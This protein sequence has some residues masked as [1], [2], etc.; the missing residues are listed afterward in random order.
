VPDEVV[1]I[2]RGDLLAGRDA[3]LEAA[4]AWIDTRQ[5]VRQ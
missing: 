2:R 4:L 3:P 5:A 1:P